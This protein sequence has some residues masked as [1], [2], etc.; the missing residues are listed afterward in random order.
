MTEKQ[1]LHPPKYSNLWFLKARL[2]LKI[3]KPD[4]QPCDYL[5]SASP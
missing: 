2:N 1:D 3:T 5:C 4:Q